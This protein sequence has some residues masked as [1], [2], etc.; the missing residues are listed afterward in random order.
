MQTNINGEDGIGGGKQK[1]KLD[2]EV[3]L[4][5]VKKNETAK[6]NEQE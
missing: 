6:R 3:T 1:L 5:K 4:T 2:T